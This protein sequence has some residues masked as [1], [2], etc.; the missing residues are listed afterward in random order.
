MGRKATDIIKNMTTFPSIVQTEYLTGPTKQLLLLSFKIQLLET[1][2]EHNI[3]ARIF[4]RSWSPG[5]DYKERIPQ[6][7]LAW[8]TGTITLLLLGS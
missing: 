8:R 1:I 3:R 2:S 5:I 6:A 7:Y 4:K